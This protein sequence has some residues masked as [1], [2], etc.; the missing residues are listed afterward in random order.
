MS[1]YTFLSGSELQIG[2]YQEGPSHMLHLP[3]D[4]LPV[5]I[6][7]EFVEPS[8][9][10]E[11]NLAETWFSY[12]NLDSLQQ[13]RW[14]YPGFGE[15]DGKLET[16]E[17]LAHRMGLKYNSDKHSMENAVHELG[18]SLFAAMSQPLR[19]AVC[20]LFHCPTDD[21]AVINNPEQAWANRIAEGIAETFKEAFLP[22]K[23]RVFPNRTNRHIGYK[24]YPEFRR[25]FRGIFTDKG[26]FDTSPV[27]KEEVSGEVGSG[28]HRGG[29][30]VNDRRVHGGRSTSRVP[31]PPPPPPLIFK[32]FSH[33]VLE[34]D[35]DNLS[36]AW[37]VHQTLELT[38]AVGS[39]AWLKRY[40]AGYDLFAH[41]MGEDHTFTYDW[42]IPNPDA[43]LLLPWVGFVVRT[44]GFFGWRFYLKKNNQYVG[45]LYKFRGGWGFNLTE[46]NMVQ[47]HTIWRN[48][49]VIFDGADLPPLSAGPWIAASSG[50]FL[51][52]SAEPEYEGEDN[53]RLFEDAIGLATLPVAQGQS[54]TVQEGDEISIHARILGLEFIGTGATEEPENR[55]RAEQGTGWLEASIGA[56]LPRLPYSYRQL[57]SVGF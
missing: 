14:D 24:Y 17:A 47:A 15:G 11:G 18:H 8:V 38:P 33:D 30:V 23:Y 3:V 44:E 45:S 16:L 39:A 9:I 20:A 12:D 54:I 40:E 37:A 32:T 51:P 6:D 29:V 36:D 5:A 21:L 43:S 55:E 31:P 52:N 25:I 27:T 46:Q 13:V 34:L 53:A 28:G 35:E 56:A 19:L 7:V 26:G 50:L 48:Q 1:I 57:D 10:P 2:R 42:M 22:S 41:K 4:D 49:A